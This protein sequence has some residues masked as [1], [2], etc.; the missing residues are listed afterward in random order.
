M[1]VT[2]TNEIIYKGVGFDSRSGKFVASLWLNG[3]KLSL[4]SF[5]S[6][7]DAS[8]AYQKALVAR[9]NGAY[10]AY[11]DAYAE[12]MDKIKSLSYVDVPEVSE[13]DIIVK[14]TSR[15]FCEWIESRLDFDV[16]IYKSSF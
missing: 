12:Y 9:R 5:D 1:N 7:V 2:N 11:D 8:D 3:F 16:K 6:A 13:Y 15:D 4:G 14:D 10:D